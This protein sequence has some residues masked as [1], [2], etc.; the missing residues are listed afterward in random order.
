[1][2]TTGIL[3]VCVSFSVGDIHRFTSPEYGVGH[4]AYSRSIGF[5][6]LARESSTECEI[7]DEV[8]Q[9]ETYC[10]QSRGE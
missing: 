1:M 5:V 2:I 4:V 7:A 6:D 3:Y 8:Y 10:Y 9:C